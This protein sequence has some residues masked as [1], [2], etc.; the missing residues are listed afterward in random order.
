MIQMKI[1]PMKQAKA[2]YSELAIERG[3][4]PSLI[5]DRDSKA[6]WVSQM[7]QW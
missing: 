1:A 7:A 3:S 6:G 5:F 4:D 2:I